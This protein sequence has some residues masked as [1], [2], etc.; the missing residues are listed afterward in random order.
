T[1]NSIKTI[2]HVLADLKARMQR[3]SQATTQTTLKR[4]SP[5]T[6]RT[7]ESLETQEK[8]VEEHHWLNS[9]KSLIPVLDSMG[10]HTQSTP[11]CDLD[12][13]AFP[14]FD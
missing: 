7:S 12:Y 4:A 14:R 11:T 10:N 6:S 13:F 2:D 8:V 5:I 9:L 3:P 1:S